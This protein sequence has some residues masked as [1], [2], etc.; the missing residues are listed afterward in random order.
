M[1]SYSG[2][3]SGAFLPSARGYS[4]HAVLGRYGAPMSFE[5]AYASAAR[6]TPIPGVFSEIVYA[7]E[8]TGRPRHAEVTLPYGW[9]G[10]EAALVREIAARVGEPVDVRIVRAPPPSSARVTV[11][12]RHSALGDVDAFT[13][14]IPLDG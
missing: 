13:A 2:R 1:R 12:S 11:T 3:S 4:A 6:P 10:D 9:D 14:R 5:E 8:M 7:S